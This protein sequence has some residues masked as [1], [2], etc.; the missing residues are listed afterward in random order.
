MGVRGVDDY[1]LEIELERPASYFDT[2]LAFSTT[3]PVRSD[4]IEQYGEL[5]WE[6]GNFVGNGG[7]LLVGWM[8]EDYVAIEKNP[9]YW[10]ADDVAIERVVFPIIKENAVGLAAFER[11]ELDVSG[12]PNEELPRILEELKDE[13]RRL[14]WAGTYYIGLNVQR[15]PTDNVN[16]RKALASA[17]DKRAIL[18][19]VLE[20]P[21]RIDAC[22]V[23]PP[24]IPGYQGCSNVG[25]EFDLGA[26]LGYLEAALDEMGVDDPGDVSINLWFNQGNEDIV[27]AV[28]EQWHTNLG[29][30]VNTAIMEWAAYLNTLEECGQ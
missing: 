30:Q 13:F 5:W 24:E 27:E 20:M 6:P 8:H 9:D 12:Y 26:A 25:Y 10:G 1:T 11:G 19:S 4:V 22:G 14:P 17:V 29:I 21:W 23:V 28:A 16:F 15:P 18:D 7:Y 2:V 3:Y